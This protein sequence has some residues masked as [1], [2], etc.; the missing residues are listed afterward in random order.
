MKLMFNLTTSAEDLDRFPEKEDLLDLMHGFDGVELMQFEEDCRGMISKERVIGLHM[1]YFPTWFDFWRGNEEA[2]LKE[3]DSREIWERI[4]GGK[5]KE[6]I[7][8]R[9]RQDLKWAHHYDVEYVVFH[10]S[11]ATIEESFSWKY[12]HTDEEVI[13]AAIELINELLKD[14][15]GKIAFLVENLWQPGLTFTRPEMTRRLLKGIQY[16]N[17]GIMLDTGHLLHTNIAIRTQEE[18]L[19]YIYS[20][21]DEHGELCKYIRG[22]HLN[23]SLTGE[24]CEKTINDP[25]KLEDT[26]GERYG[27]M[28][29]HA[30]AVDQHLPFTCE[31]IKELIE[32]ISPEY[33]TFEFITADSDQHREYLKNQKKAL[34]M[35]INE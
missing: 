11:E 22:V 29:W 17:K 16:P 5:D 20:I 34:G 21:L 4:Y 25:P 28:F 9:F 19:R 24:Y 31:G 8:N 3:F 18:G 2:L 14:E 27:K 32:R 1:G 7:L 6:A 15:D 13:D 33:L 35:E 26:Y 30:F 10:V 12:Q 23:Q